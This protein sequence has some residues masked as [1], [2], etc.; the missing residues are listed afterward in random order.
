VDEF[1]NH[2]RLLSHKNT[3]TY[4]QVFKCLPSDNVLTLADLKTYTQR[5]PLSKCDPIKGKEEL[6]QNVVGFIVDFP[7]KFLSKEANFFPQTN[8]R[9]GIV[10]TV[11]WT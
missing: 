6:E 4:D 8:T 7:L 2:F 5:S 9:E 3:L 1:Y 11:T 10:P